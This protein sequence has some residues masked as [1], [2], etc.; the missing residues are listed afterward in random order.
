VTV[1][2]VILWLL[3][4]STEKVCCVFEDAVIVIVY[5]MNYCTCIMYQNS[6]ELGERLAVFLHFVRPT[7][8]AVFRTKLITLTDDDKSGIS[9]VCRYTFANEIRVAKI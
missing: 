1:A 6:C 8:L 7:L 3:G 4:V 5:A 2:D 9:P